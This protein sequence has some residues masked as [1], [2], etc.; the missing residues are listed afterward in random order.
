M[1]GAGE[2]R[3]DGREDGPLLMGRI[4]AFAMLSGVI[5]FTIIAAVI[6]KGVLMPAA[7]PGP[8]G[9]QAMLGMPQTVGVLTAVSGVMLLTSVP[10][11][12]VL[13]RMMLSRGGE[14]GTVGAEAWTTAHLI[15]LS[16]VE[17]FALLGPVS[18][19][20]GKSVLPG[21]VIGLV[22]A[23]AML[24]HVPTRR[25]FERYVLGR[26]TGSNPYAVP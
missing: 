12:F 16:M 26:E 15:G 19:V 3:M 20:I 21:A 18:M 7:P 22:G 13:K 8:G 11:S 1:T 4:V 17:A 6:A 9:G 10:F 14:G 5:L 23:L 2:G 24:G 25:S